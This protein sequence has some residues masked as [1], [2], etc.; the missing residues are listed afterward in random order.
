MR[1]KVYAGRTESLILDRLLAIA[2]TSEFV[3][4]SVLALSALH[5]A[6][7]T[8]SQETLNISNHH[9][10]IASKGL[11]VALGAFSKEN[12]DAVLAASL[13]LSWQASDW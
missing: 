7:V 12:C 1:A 10:K 11:Q 5:M 9:R 3:M 13:I 2:V 4:S 8:G 6:Y